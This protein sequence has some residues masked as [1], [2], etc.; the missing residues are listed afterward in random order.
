MSKIRRQRRDEASMR[1]YEE[2]AAGG[3]GALV[4]EGRHI[5]K[6]HM[7]KAGQWLARAEESLARD[8]GKEQL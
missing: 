1:P 2:A 4:Y 5:D 7:D 6:A 8:A 3:A